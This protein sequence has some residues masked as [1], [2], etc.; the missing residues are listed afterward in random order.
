M[1]TVTPLL[2]IGPTEYGIVLPMTI[3]QRQCSALQSM[4][5]SEIKIDAK[6]LRFLNKTTPQ[7]RRKARPLSSNSELN[8]HTMQSSSC[9]SALKLRSLQYYQEPHSYDNPSP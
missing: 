1:L 5:Y 7:F 8:L 3:P 6:R 2:S 4:F 9:V